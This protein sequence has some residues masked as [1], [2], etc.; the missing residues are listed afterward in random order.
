M[1]NIIVICPNQ[2]SR[3]LMKKYRQSDVFSNVKFYSRETFL[4]K[5]TYRY[6]LEAVKYLIKN[7]DLSLKIAKQYLRNI[8]YLKDYD[9][10]I[11]LPFKYLFDIKQELIDNNLLIEDTLFKYQMNNAHIDIAYYSKND[12]VIAFCL[13]NHKDYSFI[14]VLKD[15]DYVSTYNVFEN[16]DDELYFVIN[17]IEDLLKHQGVKP[18]KIRLFNFVEDD[19]II[20]DRF[21]DNYHFNIDNA[22]EKNIASINQSKNILSNYDGTLDSLIN[23]INFDEDGAFDLSSCIESFYIEG[24]SKDKQISV[25]KDAFK[26]VL[27]TPIKH[28]DALK[29]INDPFVDKDE[30]LF[31][32]NYAQGKFPTFKKDD[33]FLSDDEKKI[34]NIPISEEINDAISDYY[35]NAL[36]GDG[37]IVLCYIN[38]DFSAKYS[39]SFFVDALKQKEIYAPT[40]ETIYSQK[41]ANIKCAKL[42]DVK[43]KYHRID[44]YLESLEK[45]ADISYGNYDSQ[46]NNLDLYND[47]S[48]LELSY[49]QIKVFVECQ[50]KYYLDYILN[51]DPKDE[52]INL[53]LGNLFHKMLENKQK[54]A[55]FDENYDANYQNYINKLSEIE[56][57]FLKRMIE[58]FRYSYQYIE[59]HDKNVKNR[60]EDNE[61][62]VSIPLGNTL[63]KGKIDKIMESDS[64]YLSIIDYKL[65]S[66]KFNENEF[67]EYSRSSQLPIYSYFVKNDKYFK[68]KEVINLLISPLVVSDNKKLSFKDN[69]NRDKMRQLIGISLNEKNKL[70]TFSDDFSYYGSISVTKKGDF[71]KRSAVYSKVKI[72]EFADKAEQ[73]IKTVD[74]KVRTN[75]F[76]INPKY[77]SSFDNSCK[78]CHYHDICFKNFKQYVYLNKGG[79]DDE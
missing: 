8:I 34:L 39:P 12:P 28:K 65:S 38:H 20:I 33:A 53:V 18:N 66:E 48:K 70:E 67:N 43:T 36:R 76:I 69:E 19:E 17:K 47:K 63:I 14:D 79:S 44:P 27:R 23:N 1:K 56:K 13:K 75:E 61:Y 57:I 5:C 42:L 55:S 35:K 9:E 30:Y 58:E 7:Y 73:L 71:T 4:K 46:I 40:I 24:L 54:Y 45:L 59:S 3:I 49:S 31:I 26:T 22:F 74:K 37:H 60:W 72:D 64:Q 2:T 62:E 41:E 6:D 29:V 52:N 50:Y 51:I 16:N 15:N 77:K 68:D 21:R 32:L 25:Y 78:F 10:S 11:H